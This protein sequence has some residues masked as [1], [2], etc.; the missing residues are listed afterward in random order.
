[1]RR[2]LASC[3]VIGAICVAAWTAKAANSII[4][5]STAAL[6]AD[7]SLQKVL[8]NK[9]AKAAQTF[10][11][12]QF[13][14]TNNVG[15]TRSSAQFLR[16][17]AAGSADN[18]T[19]YMV[20]TARDYG[21]LSIVTGSAIRRGHPDAF[22]SRFWVKQ[23]AGWRLLVHQET[24]FVENAPNGQQAAQ[25]KGEA[26]APDCENPCRT[27]PFTAKTRG[28]EEVVKVLQ[29]LETAVTGHDPKTWAYYVVDEF[30]NIP[31]LYT[32]S[33]ETKAVRMGQIVDKSVTVIVPKIVSLQVLEFNGAA[34]MLA[35][36]QPNGEKPFHVIR[37]WV[38]RDGRWQ[39]FFS[40]GTTIE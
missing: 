2:L 27:S 15:L 21:R 7:Q 26:A 20:S 10:L 14:W 24:S 8:K 36:H 38:K 31:R 28:Q 40:Q 5:P 22:F 35:D 3:L 39:L 16:D 29:I 30:V 9:D 23:P 18:D 4:P 25:G 34:I 11:D 1:M 12:Q 19:E 33:P 32:G 13:S 17:V 6:K 37:A